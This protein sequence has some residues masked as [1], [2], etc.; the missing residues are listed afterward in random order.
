MKKTVKWG[1][2]GP[3][4]VSRL[5]AEGLRSA[6]GAV[7]EAVGSRTLERG[8]KFA[9]E[10]GVGN[11]YG[12][13]SDLISRPGIDAV[14]IGTPHS[15]HREHTILCLE[16]G[17]NVLCEKP[18]AI[19]ASQAKEM[20]AAA[21]RRNLALMEAMWIRFL[22]ALKGACEL[23]GEGVI[24]EVREVTADFGFRSEFDPEGRL[25][26][27]ALGGGALL[28]VGV[29]TVTLAHLILGRP[30]TV[31]AT[32]RIGRTGVDE[33]TEVLF[34]YEGGA[35]AVLTM[36]ISR[37]TSCDAC[38]TGSKGA[39]FIPAPWWKSERFELAREDES[40]RRFHLPY[41][42]NGYTH[43]ADEFMDMI[44]TGKQE[45]E[46]MPLDESVSVMKSLDR[47]RNKLGLRYPME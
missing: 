14:Y 5:F 24:G 16:G 4:A 30:D 21:R 18:F 22:P 8:R 13:Y 19:N 2:L 17:K 38:I 35:R 37:E 28:D 45:S 42:G 25:F 29:Y 33:E 47:I 43:Q 26:N 6:A 10:F 20:A 40:K 44:R 9:L 32:A 23:I 41:G 1:I 31:E 34:G 12:S 15:F 3:G 39:V 36:A 11:W 27:P 46:I 7:I